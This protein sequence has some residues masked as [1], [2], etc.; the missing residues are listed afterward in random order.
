MLLSQ[1]PRGPGE[2]I[3]RC[4]QLEPHQVDPLAAAV[5]GR[6]QVTLGLPP[7][8]CAAVTSSALQ[9]DGPEE[10]VR[11]LQQLHPACGSREPSKHC[12]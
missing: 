9:R 8:L 7:G 11:H 3:S 4:L 10:Q 2:A 12:G 1:G 5:C 6:E